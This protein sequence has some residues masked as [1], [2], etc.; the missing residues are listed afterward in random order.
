[1]E[2]KDRPIMK[3]I[4]ERWQYDILQGIIGLQNI[5][6]VDCI[7]LSGSMAEFVDVEY[8]EREA[9]REIVTSSFVVRKATAGNYS[10]MI[11]AALLGLN[12]L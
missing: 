6:D 3:K 5:F 4:L 7:V 9:N 11:G 1:M 10:G 2:N 12:I 8:I